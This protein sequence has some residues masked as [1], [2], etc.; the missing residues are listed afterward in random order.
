MPYARVNDVDL[1]YELVGRGLPLVMIG[2]LGATTRACAPLAQQFRHRY[3]TL[4]YDHRGVGKSGKPDVQYSLGMYAADLAGLLD[5]LRIEKANVLGMSMGG[6]V[7]QQFVL[8]H[9]DRVNRVVLVT[10]AGHITNYMRRIGLLFRSFIAHL[11]PEEFARTL[12]TLSFTASFV[13]KA[14]ET[15]AEVE[16]LLVPDPADIAGIKRQVS[17][18]AGGDFS[19][20]LDQ[21]RAP[22]LVIA[23]A[24][25]ILTPLEYSRMLAEAI[26]G[27]RLAVMEESAHNPLVEQSAK[28]ART[29]IDFLEGL[30]PTDV[31]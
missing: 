14:P 24:R 20:R 13:E 23:G 3:A 18:L 30:S 29:V 4:I 22:V 7:A 12:T 28:C 2:G 19:E 11:P 8:D 31:A 6:I 16:R 26:P 10:T 17:M 1:Y 5:H 21:I 27:A 15:V 25:D 9:P